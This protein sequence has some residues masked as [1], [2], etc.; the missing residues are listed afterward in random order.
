MTTGVLLYCFDTET[1]KYHNLAERCILQA[2]EYLDL[3]ITVV[4]NK[5]TQS[6]LKSKSVEYKIVTEK[7]GNTRTYRGQN[8]PWHNKERALAYEHSPYEN[9][10][11]MDCDYFVFSDTLLQLSASQ[12]D[13]LLHHDTH[14]LTGEDMIVGSDESTLPLVWATVTLFRKTT[15]TRAVFD[16]I[17]HVQAYYSHYRNLYRIKYNNYRNDY[18]FAIALHQLSLGSK[19]PTPMAMLPI[20]VDV[21]DSN[22]S[23]VVFKYG[24]YTNFITG[25]DVH[26]MDKEWC[27]V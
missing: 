12:Y 24:N 4:T 3:P 25:Q 13:I 18:A 21:T 11:L 5:D 15:N 23:G 6:R 27:D 20:G 17:K 2:Q 9:T 26:I 19:I 7:T 22:A 8:V 14:D 16:M 10:I 1:A